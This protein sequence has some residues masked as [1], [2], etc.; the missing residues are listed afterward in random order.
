MEYITLGISIISMLAGIISAVVAVKSKNESKDIL[1]E[2]K[3]INID[4]GIHSN[5]DNINVS[6]GNSGIVAGKIHGGVTNNGK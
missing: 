5:S 2:I 3:E 6:G 4:K 1:K